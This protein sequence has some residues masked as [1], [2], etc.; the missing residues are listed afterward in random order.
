MTE[1]TDHILTLF[2]NYSKHMDS[3]QVNNTHT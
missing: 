3:V 1:L 2:M